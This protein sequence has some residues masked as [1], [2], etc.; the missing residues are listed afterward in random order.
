MAHTRSIYTV[1]QEDFQANNGVIEEAVVLCAVV[2]GIAQEPVVRC[3]IISGA[4][5]AQVEER[6]TDDHSV[7]GKESVVHHPIVTIEALQ[8]VDA[9][10]S[11][12]PIVSE[13]PIVGCVRMRECLCVCDVS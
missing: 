6:T 12:E 4:V 13:G 3:T 5:V 10:V 2:A 11:K 8:P 1:A 9:I 7:V